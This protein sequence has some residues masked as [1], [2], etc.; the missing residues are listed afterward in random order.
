MSVISLD[1][2]ITSNLNIL[3]PSVFNAEE[4][5]GIDN[6]VQAHFPEF[7]TEDHPRFLAFM[8]SYYQW[9]ESKRNVLYD[10]RRISNYQDID[11]SIDVFVEQFFKEFLTNIPRSVLTDKAL[12]LKNIKQFY[13]ARGTE[14]SYKLFFRM[15]YDTDVEFYYPR[16]DVLK[17][18]DGK[19]VQDK[20][21]RVFILSGN[22]A[23]L[24]SLK[25]RGMT[26]NSTAFVERVFSIREGST[27][28]YELVLNRSSITGPFLPEEIIEAEYVENGTKTIIT[29]R[30]SPVPI[31]GVVSVP[32]KGYSVGQTFNIGIEN[33]GSGAQI[34]IEEV[35]DEGGIKKIS[36]KKYGLGYKLSK[37]LTNI[38][39]ESNTADEFAIINF[40][41][42]A[43]INYPGYYMN[44]DGHLSTTKYIHDGE[45]YQQFSYVVYVNET[46]SRYR[47]AL[48][49]L[50]HPIGYKLFG[51]FRSEEVLKAKL[52]V[53]EYPNRSRELLRTIH[54]QVVNA[55]A[56]MHLSVNL[57]HDINRN[58]KTYALGPSVNSIYRDRFRYKPFS[59]PIRYEPVPAESRHINSE[60]PGTPNY[61]GP[62][63]D[64][65]NQKA[66]TPISV[67]AEDKK[68]TP[69]KIDTELFQKTNLLPDAVVI[70]RPI[71]EDEDSE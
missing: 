32:G 68:L 19:W 58:P 60:L 23:K 1:S 24:K 42:G 44:E 43:L 50:I 39:L 56:K 37:P 4:F 14:K 15:L 26:K 49:S 22:G 11:T 71:T 5:P 69:H 6:F 55:K 40:E 13:R 35:D 59:R 10:S 34:K 33:A 46:I 64:L 38:T 18:S 61:F 57:K 48:K 52:G 53:S 8:K 27:V 30:V 9:M 41:L 28:G 47:N 2:L 31:K 3:Y 36:I 25:I 7:V 29:A 54:S 62:S 17:P 51:G 20:T 45:Y 12:L 65:G 67:F 21:L 70:S 63:N 16:V 66:I